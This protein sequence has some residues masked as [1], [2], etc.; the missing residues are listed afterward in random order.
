MKI[1]GTRNSW[2]R[3]APVINGTI[4]DMA[5]SLIHIGF[6]FEL[7]SR[8]VV[9][10]VLTQIVVDYDQLHAMIDQL[11]PPKSGSKS[12][13]EVFQDIHADDRLPVF[14]W[15]ED[16]CLVPIVKK[17]ADILQL[18][19]DEWKIDVNYLEKPIE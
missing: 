5:Y 16:E 13:L 4:C 10:E 9:I 8:I 2:T 6:A 18:H 15:P 19:Y 17:S 12:A 11:K 7:D 3:E 1:I 14:A